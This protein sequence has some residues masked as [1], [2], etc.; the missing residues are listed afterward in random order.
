MCGRAASQIRDTLPA[1]DATLKACLRFA[2]VR[3]LIMLVSGSR[4]SVYQCGEEVQTTVLVHL[5]YRVLLQHFVKRGTFFVNQ[6]ISGN[7]LHVKT[8]CL[9]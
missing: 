1:E 9:L 3:N 4:K 8:D 5:R 6:M 7:M 2:E